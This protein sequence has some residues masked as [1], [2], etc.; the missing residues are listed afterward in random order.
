M[1]ESSKSS[2]IAHTLGERI[3]VAGSYQTTVCS[4]P[5][6]VEQVS[7]NI[8]NSRRLRTLSLFCT[9]ARSSA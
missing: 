2:I 3:A 4:S 6:K 7:T 9:A 1:F 8:R 5:A